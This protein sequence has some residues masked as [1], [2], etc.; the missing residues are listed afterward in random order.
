MF[1]ALT[2][3]VG[4]FGAMCGSYLAPALIDKGKRK[5]M[6]W[7]NVLVIITYAVQAAFF[8]MPAQI[9]AKFFQGICGGAFSVFSPSLLNDF[10]PI[11]IAG[12]MGG[13]NQIWVTFGILMPSLMAWPI[14]G[15]IK[16]TNMNEDPSYG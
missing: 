12:P 14:P 11:E 10:S 9:I 16:D 2:T 7:F 8:N 3:S 4:N 6:I 15:E 1:V 5:M 13:L